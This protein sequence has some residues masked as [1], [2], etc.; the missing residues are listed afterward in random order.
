L[1]TKGTSLRFSVDSGSSPEVNEVILRV[2]I[3][4]D[5]GVQHDGDA[6]TIDK[7]SFAE[8]LESLSPELD[9]VVADRLGGE[10]R[11][12]ACRLK[13]S[14]INDFHPDGVVDQV[15]VLAGLVRAR[16]TLNACM[17]GEAEL[18]DVREEVAAAFSGTAI[19][20]VLTS[21]VPP[22]PATDIGPQSQA[23]GGDA[24][25]SLLAKV[26]LPADS[27]PPQSAQSLASLLTS[28]VIPVQ[29]RAHD[30]EE[31]QALID[32]IDTRLTRQVAAICNHQKVAALEEAWR[33]LHMLVSRTDFRAGIRLEVLPSS[34]ESFLNDFFAKVF[35][36]EYDNLSTNPLSLVLADFSFSRSAEDLEHLKNAARIAESLN[37]PFILAMGPQFW[38]VKQAK[39][40]GSLPDLAKKASGS[41]YAKWTSFRNE[42]SSLWL[43]LTANRLA[44][45]N[46]WHEEVP[47]VKKLSWTETA[48]SAATTPLWG[49]GVW[50]M[51]VSL[52]QSFAEQGVRFPCCGADSP[53]ALGD[54]PLVE[55][56]SKGATFPYSLE[57]RYP[58]TKVFELSQAGFAPLIAK[59]GSDAAY[60]QSAPTFHKPTRYSTKEATRA[61]FLA[62]S[63]PY[64]AFAGIVAHTVQRVGMSVGGGAS[65]AD[66][67]QRFRD[68]LLAFLATCEE[69]PEPDEILVEVSE[70]EEAPEM[71]YVAIRLRPRFSISGGEVDLVVG[72]SIP[73]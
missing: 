35:Q 29:G 43:C 63:L 7:Q 17:K 64:Q 31:L 68:R 10:E 19:G 9:F 54:L 58:E 1:D 23:T 4:A 20:K 65:E 71:L 22:D 34:R 42:E 57:A 38:G 44:L 37:V 21:S 59:Q 36:Q 50:A 61:S 32:E 3:F 12:L 30:T 48:D 49:S 26:D 8:V 41:E 55:Y 16:A 27:P 6:V 13:F 51:G 56:Q 73:R 24:L 25:E 60:F 11:E 53:G 69:A 47:T 14:H 72:T 18:T 70:S 66:I 28:A 45:R 62:A 15:P 2:M 46:G 40:V 33:G 67:V 52:T 5:L 39:L